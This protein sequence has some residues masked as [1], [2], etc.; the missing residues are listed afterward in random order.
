MAG[1][2]T[3]ILNN[4]IYSKTIIGSQKIADGTIT[5]S[6]FSSNVTVPGDFLISGNLFV[7]GSSSYTTIASTNTYVNDPLVVLNNGFA[8]TNTYDEGL[9]FNRGSGTNQ[10]FIWSEFFGEFRLIATSETGTTYGN[11]NGS[12]LVRLSVGS[13]NV[14]G[15]ANIGSLSLSGGI[16]AASL[17]VS[18]NVLAAAGV[19]NALTVNGNETVTGYL[20]VTGNVMAKEITGNSL[21]VTGNVSTALLNAGQINTTGN[22]LATAGTF[23]ALTVN[24]NETV[25]GY[26][27]VSGNVLTASLSAGQINTTGNVLAAAAV[28]NTLTVNGNET[29]TGY[30]NVSGNVLSAGA[31]HNNLTVNGNTSLGIAGAVSGSWTTVVGNITQSTSGGAVYFN[32]A[33]NVMAAVGQFGAINSTGYINTSGN[34]STAQ[35]NAGQINTTGNILAPAAVVNALTVNGNESVTGYLNVSGN[36]L[37]AQLNAGQI[38]TTGNVLAAGGVYNA[39][40]VNGNESVT[41]YLNVSGNVLASAIIGAS[42]NVSGN[43]LG[44]AATFSSAQ[45]NGN[46]SVTGYLNVAGNILGSA[47]TLTTLVLNSTTNATGVNNGGALTV[48]GGASFAQ[49]VYIGGNLYAANIIGVTA[50]VITVQDPLLYLRPGNV[51]P[52]NYDIGIYSAFVGPGLS[53]LANVYQHTGVIRDQHNNTWTFASNLAEPGGGVVLFDSTTVYDPIK[54]GN[55]SLVTN[56][57]STSTSTGALIVTGGA[58]I[59]GAVVAAQLN[60]TGNVLGQ[61]AIFNAL[62]VNGTTTLTGFLNSSANISAVIVNAGAINSTGYINTSGN[63]STAQLNAGQINTT[64][65]VLSAGAVHNALTVNG[66]AN[67]TTLNATTITATGNVIGGLGQFA[68]INSTP[69]GNA[70]ASTGAFTTLNASGVTTLTGNLSLSG[71]SNIIAGGSPGTNGQVLQATGTGVQWVSLTASSSQIYSGGS[72]VTV[73]ANYVNVSVNGTNVATFSSTGLNGAAIGASTSST[74]KFTTLQATSTVTFDNY[75]GYLKSAGAGGLSASSTIPNTDVSGLGTMS[76]QNSNSVTI[77]GGSIDG[78][79]IGLSTAGSARFTSVTITDTTDTT[80]ANTGA[81]QVQGG[82]YVG[83]TLWVGENAVFNSTQTAEDFR[84]LGLGASTNNSLVYVNA[85]KNAIVFGGANVSVQDGAVAKFNSDGA[86]VLPVGATARRPST[87]GNVDVAGMIRFN[88]TINN[89]EFYDGSAWQTAGSSFTVISDRQFSGNVAGGYGNVDGTNKDFTLQSS[90]TTSGTIVSINGILQFPTLAY[91]VSGT[92]LSFTE[93]PAPDDVIDA[94]ILTTTTTIAS[95]ASSNG[96]NQFIVDNTYANIQT[97]SA[98]TTPRISVNNA[99]NISIPNGSPIIYN[100]SNIAAQGTNVKLIDSFST[101]TYGTA[102]YL[103]QIKDGAN[104]ESAEVLLAQDGVNVSIT[105]YAVIA[106]AGTLGTFQSN[107]S[108][109]TVRFWYTPSIS[110][111]AN[112]KMQTTYITAM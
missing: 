29:V 16:S 74:G 4:Q 96:F 56:I 45:I 105:T 95:V 82:A 18:G 71:S 13:L 12:G 37:T 109:G 31:I 46:E 6:L 60:S 21:N 27:N 23:N 38:N 103:V 110:T 33:G 89:V 25:T 62:T 1:N 19:Y 17:N 26:L 93:A 70:S 14:L 90:A 52:Y 84:I 86:I 48:S 57:P 94:R 53:T 5:G 8:G 76:T 34:I 112:I 85:S 68:A 98:T 88:T 9:I 7:L 44:A 99:G 41:G 30:L 66:T 75:T 104:I 101:A 3:R 111:Y 55:L 64:G 36:V 81:F 80:A 39:L 2:L 58:G 79:S 72:N 28:V 102:K 108:S 100:Q 87:A 73:T 54:A 49:D 77:T 83:R 40:T 61:G 22:V 92:T 51:Y 11:V 43:V 35:L 67:V 24:G 42:L 78:A 65:N 69:I 32:T 106:P 107:I 59:G 20:N 15:Q 50:N 47:G 97:G 10:A 91:S 63:I